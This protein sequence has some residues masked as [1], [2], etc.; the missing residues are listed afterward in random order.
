MKTIT[1]RDVRQHW[2][3]AER[4]LEVER[5]IIITRD[6][7]PVAKLSRITPKTKK[8]KRFDPIAHRKWKEQLWGKG[9]TV[10]WVQEFC[11]KDRAERF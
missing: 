8:R 9:V 7:R 1:V 2:P 6:G 10:N 3:E 11:E 4:A 5:E